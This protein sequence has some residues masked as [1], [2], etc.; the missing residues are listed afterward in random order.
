M[1]GSDTVRKVCGFDFFQIWRKHA[2]ARMQAL[3]FDSFL[4][5]ELGL[6]VEDKYIEFSCSK[7]CIARIF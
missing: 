5:L 6:V 7:Q 1:Q 2:C 3:H 4:A